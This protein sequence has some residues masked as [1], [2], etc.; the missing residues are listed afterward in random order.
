MSISM[1]ID[2]DKEKRGDFIRDNE[3]QI[4]DNF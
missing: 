4:T 1:C 2:R 3:A